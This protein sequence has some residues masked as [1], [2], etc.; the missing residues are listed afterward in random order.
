MKFNFVTLW[1]VC[2]SV[3]SSSFNNQRVRGK[4]AIQ[5]RNLMDQE[6]EPCTTMEELDLGSLDACEADLIGRR[7]ENTMESSCPHTK[8]REAKLLAGMEGLTATQEYFVNECERIKGGNG[9]KSR[10]GTARCLEDFD[11]QINGC[12]YRSVIKG[13]RAELPRSCSHNV[14]KELQLLTGT[15]NDDDAKEYISELCDNAWD[16]VD[17]TTYQNIHSD[18]SNDF[19][20]EYTDGGGYL[21]TETGNF[22]GVQSLKYRTS[23]RSLSAGQSIDSY[24]QSDSNGASN[25]RL[26]ATFENL[27]NCE[28]QSIMCCFGRDR[29]SNDDNGQCRSRQCD[30]SDPANNSN[31]C[32]TEPSLTPY[33]QSEEGNVHCHGLAWAEDEN[34]F[35]S[36]LKFNNFFYVS[37]YDHMYT[38]GYVQNMISDKSDNTDYVPMCSCIENMPPVSRADCTQVDV[39]VTFNLFL[40]SNGM[41]EA[42]SENDL[43][44]AFNACQGFRYSNNLLTANNDLASYA[45]RLVREGKMSTETQS[46]M[47]ETL[48]GYALPNANDNEEVCIDKYE[49]LTGK[50]YPQ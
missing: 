38:R 50:E 4:S 30:N 17:K 49:D 13:I 33:P 22:Q 35:I 48:L 23:A 11:I 46:R 28:L 19:M 26:E 18:F 37:M 15:T 27:Q 44:I 3:S 21:N 6:K 39:D 5:S 10:D 16:M 20:N 8:W 9:D 24:Y 12:D 43:E 47:Y 40:G 32:Y 1:F 31:L 29:Q 41:I 2:Q 36:Q 25:S 7:I 14:Q 34:D 42:E 45:V